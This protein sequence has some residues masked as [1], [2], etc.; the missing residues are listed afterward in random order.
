LAGAGW[1]FLREITI[2]AQ[3]HHPHILPLYDSGEAAGFLIWVM[4][5]KR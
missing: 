1:R 5:C 2:A 3:L 4:D